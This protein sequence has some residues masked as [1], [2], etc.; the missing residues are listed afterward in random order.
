MTVRIRTIDYDH[1]GH[2]LG[3]QLTW[4]DEWTRARP[5][6]VVYHDAMKSN[7]GFEEE[8]AVRLTGM[9]YA[10]F[11]ADTYGRG[12]HCETNEESYAQM[13]P[14]QADRT[15][16]QTRLR[17]ALDAAAAQP[18]VDGEQLAAIG[19]CF[20]GMC[21]LD[22]ARMNAPVKGVGSF[23]GLLTPPWDEKR[24]PRDA[25]EAKVLVMHGWDDP[26]ATPDTIE[27][28]AREMTE[29]GADWQLLAFG[30]T[31]H[32]FTNPRYDMPEEGVAYDEKADRRSWRALADFLAELFG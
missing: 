7:Q 18:E 4:D 1:D 20:G 23:H 13:Q 5:C 25:I 28:L 26:Y 24:A 15:F 10:G 30:H 31:L 17:A 27:P 3:G 9:G 11:V 2:P 21:V 8:R 12:V 29:R 32:S 14:F 6:V 22:L 19:Y 16:L